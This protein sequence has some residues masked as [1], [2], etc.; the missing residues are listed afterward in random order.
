MKLANNLAFEPTL[1]KLESMYN[2]K[3]EKEQLNTLRLGF[4]NGVDIH[5]YANP[6]LDWTYMNRIRQSLEKGIDISKY[7]NSDSVPQFVEI[8]YTLAVSGVNIEQF[9]ER[10]ELNIEDILDAYNLQMRVRNLEPLDSVL[11]DALC[12]IGPYYVNK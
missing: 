1:A 6:K 10:G 2:C 9:V 8:I 7:V 3:Y 5:K 4:E 11:E 12:L